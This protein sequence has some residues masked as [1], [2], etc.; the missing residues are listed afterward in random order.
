MAP[1][2]RAKRAR[3]SN[4]REVVSPPSYIK[5]T[6]GI[7]FTKREH[8]DN[9]YNL[10]PR[11]LFSTRFYDRETTTLL[12]IDEDVRMLARN[13]GLEAFI[14]LNAPTFARI[15][16]EFL[17]SLEVHED[18]HGDSPPTLSFQV[19]NNDHSIPLSFLNEAFHFPKPFD[20][21]SYIYPAFETL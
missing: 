17:A 19:F 4:H 18:E 7:E 5:E 2:R 3:C 8:W 10:S 15:T 9:F 21:T 13:L 1:F 12:G 14:D 20:G 11:K 6:Y 16:F